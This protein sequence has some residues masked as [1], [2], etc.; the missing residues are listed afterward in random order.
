MFAG[1]KRKLAEKQIMAFF[2]KLRWQ[3]ATVI[4]QNNLLFILKF[5]LVIWTHPLPPGHNIFR[6]QKTKH[7]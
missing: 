2:E 1:T 3:L 7:V 6:S 5:F 4:S